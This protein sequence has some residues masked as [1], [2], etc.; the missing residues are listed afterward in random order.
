MTWI[1]GQV[2]GCGN[3]KR[4]GGYFSSSQDA[5]SKTNNF[6]LADG[7]LSERAQNKPTIPV[8]VILTIFPLSYVY[9][10]STSIQNQY[11]TNAHE[12][13]ATNTCL[14]WLTSK[15]SE[16]EEGKPRIACK[17]QKQRSQRTQKMC[18]KLIKH[19][20]H[21][22]KIEIVTQICLVSLQA[23]V[24]QQ[25]ALAC[26]QG[27]KCFWLSSI[28]YN[29]I[30]DNNHTG[31]VAANRSIKQQLQSKQGASQSSSF[32]FSLT[33][34]KFGCDGLLALQATLHLDA[35]LSTDNDMTTGFKQDV[36]SRVTADLTFSSIWCFWFWWQLCS[37]SRCTENMDIIVKKIKYLRTKVWNIE[38][39]VQSI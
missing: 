23:A 15:V 2:R 9:S 34:S 22:L 5:E 25:P 30:K 8:K 1:C 28:T 35:A 14:V 12:S 20:K 36:S 17:Q 3:H 18:H 16:A 13:E 10:T 32:F 4:K 38:A 29:L 33:F 26:R 24:M 37:V 21:T 27:M 39:V 11:E 31:W 6:L 7:Q 19:L